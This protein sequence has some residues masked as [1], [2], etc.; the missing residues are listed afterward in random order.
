VELGSRIVKDGN[1]TAEVIGRIRAMLAFQFTLPVQPQEGRIAR[2][3][4]VAS[5]GAI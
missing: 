2:S 1:R 3:N 4:D 5:S